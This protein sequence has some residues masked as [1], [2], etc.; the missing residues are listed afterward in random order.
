MWATK[1]GLDRVQIEIEK[2][3]KK[4]GGSGRNSETQSWVGRENGDGRFDVGGVLEAE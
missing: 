1:T 3:R 2:E 4:E